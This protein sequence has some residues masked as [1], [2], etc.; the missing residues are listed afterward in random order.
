[1]LMAM[2]PDSTLNIDTFRVNIDKATSTQTN[3]VLNPFSNGYVVPW[4]VGMTLDASTGLVPTYKKWL[5]TSYFSGG[6]WLYA[7]TFPAS[8][9][10]WDSASPPPT[11]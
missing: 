9:K 4:T 3:K 10:H 7:C 2:M 5:A 1:M 8:M 11:G 6:S